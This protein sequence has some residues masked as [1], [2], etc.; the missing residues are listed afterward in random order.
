MN[1][2]DI[3]DKFKGMDCVI[4]TCGPSLKE[5][6]DDVIREFCKDKVVICVKESYKEFRDICNIFLANT[7]REKRYGI[8]NTKENF[9]SIFTAKPFHTAP[10]YEEYH[11]VLKEDYPFKKETQLLRTLK[12]SD[13]LFDIN[14][15]RPW[16][17]G[18][19]YEVAF[20]V[21]MHVGIKNI[22]TIG[23]DL[24]DIDNS[25]KIT[26]YF[27]DDYENYKDSKRW[28]KENFKEEMQLVN[29]QIIHMYKFMRS[30]GINIFVCGEQS[31]V[32]RGIPR[33]SLPVSEDKDEDDEDQG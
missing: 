14:E 11:I 10:R 1:I 6:P 30:K 20:Y 31:F 21:C 32:N 18:I 24:I 15:D 16:G 28:I 8:D 22:Y 26:H 4:L 12:F 13:Y 29:T 33:I 9:I 3:K 25:T 19:M 5:H 23:W 17:P 27:E 7:S 2:K